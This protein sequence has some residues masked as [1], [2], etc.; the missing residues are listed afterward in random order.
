MPDAIAAACVPKTGPECHP[1]S[2]IWVPCRAWPTR[3]PTS[4]PAI[5]A[6][7]SSRP[8]VV[9]DRVAAVDSSA[10]ISSEQLC[11]GANG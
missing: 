11:S 10:G 7:S 4:N 3:G 2:S 9:A 1:R 5:A 8:V 6:S